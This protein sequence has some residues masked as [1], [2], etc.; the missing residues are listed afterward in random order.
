MRNKLTFS[1][2]K[3]SN[4]IIGK[5]KSQWKIIK[6]PYKKGKVIK[7][8]IVT[9]DMI[10]S[11]VINQIEREFNINKVLMNYPKMHSVMIPTNVGKLVNKGSDSHLLHYVYI[12]M[13]KMDGDQS[14]GKKIEFILQILVVL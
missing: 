14:T 5:G 7:F 3:K 6:H 12:E 11:R 4:K 10:G 9:S 13:D 1:F 8:V 2:F